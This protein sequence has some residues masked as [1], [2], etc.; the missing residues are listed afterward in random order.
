MAAATHANPLAWPGCTQRMEGA[1][2]GRR[3]GLDDGLK[4][5]LRKGPV[6]NAAL[7]R[8]GMQ[9]SLPPVATRTPPAA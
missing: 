2:G 9:F 7:I 5:H 1:W 8:R 3:R 4:D 6:A